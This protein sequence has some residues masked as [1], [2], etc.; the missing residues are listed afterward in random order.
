M[1]YKVG[2]QVQII[3]ERVDNWNPIM[4]RFFNSILTI[5]KV[6]TRAKGYR[7]KEDGGE[8][9]WECGMIKGKIFLSEKKIM[10]A[11]HEEFNAKHERTKTYYLRFEAIKVNQECNYLN[12]HTK[13]KNFTF[14]GQLESLFIQ[15][16][17]TEK[18]IY[19]LPKWCQCLK[20]V[21][22]EELEEEE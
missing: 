10:V 1:K 8:W 22:V 4:D 2:D 3:D 19:K 21:P 13:K 18:E 17:F 5:D 12:Y 14:D 11:E 15:T 7:V 16:Q 6:D 9:F 20:W